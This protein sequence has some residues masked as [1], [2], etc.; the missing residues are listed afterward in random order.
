MSFG[1]DKEFVK[2]SYLNAINTSKFISLPISTFPVFRATVLAYHLSMK[3]KDIC[4][5]ILSRIISDHPIGKVEEGKDICNMKNLQLK[6]VNYWNVQK[7]GQD[8]C[9]ST[10]NNIYS[11]SMVC[12]SQIYKLRENDDCIKLLKKFCCV[13]N[14]VITQTGY[15]GQSIMPLLHLNQK[16]SMPSITLLCF[17]SLLFS[18]FAINK[19]ELHISIRISII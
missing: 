5:Q 13:G 1:K 7:I 8:N 4:Y 6:I 19:K 9:S 17:F 3:N 16:I 14:N 10:F 12:K 2:Y 11:S 15:L 18:F